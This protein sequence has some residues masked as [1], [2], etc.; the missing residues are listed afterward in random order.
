MLC[1]ALALCKYLAVARWSR[2]VWNADDMKMTCLRK[3]SEKGSGR[4]DLSPILMALIDTIL[5]RES[6]NPLLVAASTIQS[7]FP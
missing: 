5:D 7:F 4:Q 2:H 1:F 3:R 6:R